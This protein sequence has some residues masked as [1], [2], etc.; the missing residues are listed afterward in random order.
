MLNEQI[1]GLAIVGT[2][3]TAISIQGAELS[4]HERSD[5]WRGRQ[6]LNQSRKQNPERFSRSAP[7]QPMCVFRK[8]RSFN[9]API[10][11]PCTN[12]RSVQGIPL[13]KCYHPA[14][15]KEQNLPIWGGGGQSLRRT[16]WFP[17]IWHLSR[18]KWMAHNETN[19][20]IMRPSP[21]PTVRWPVQ[22][23]TF[24]VQLD[25]SLHSVTRTTWK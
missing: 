20:A 4:Q 14:K 1:E 25:D 21:F 23:G 10:R 12:W 15:C 24:P 7:R 8:Y 2:V 19:S 6:F 9:T 11:I 16:I 22:C 17:G 3:G 5:G 18:E 13:S